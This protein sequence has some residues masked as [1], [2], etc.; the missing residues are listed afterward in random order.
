MYPWKFEGRQA[1]THKKK[2]RDEE[3]YGGKNNL[4]NWRNREMYPGEKVQNKMMN[5]RKK[6]KKNDIW[7]KWNGASNG[8]QNTQEIK[9]TLFN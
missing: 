4:K 8:T 2:W 9:R 7:R 6:W 5:P 1:C 3:M